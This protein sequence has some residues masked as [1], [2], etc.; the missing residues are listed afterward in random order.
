MNNLKTP[1]QLIYFTNDELNSNIGLSLD[2]SLNPTMWYKERDDIISK[3]NFLNKKFDKYFPEY[4][5]VDKL[6]LQFREYDS[7][8]LCSIPMNKYICIITLNTNNEHKATYKLHVYYVSGNN[9][10]ENIGVFY[11]YYA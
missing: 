3:C 7:P 8:C 9:K 10:Y 6:I 5:N 11:S 1:N 2:K 4:T